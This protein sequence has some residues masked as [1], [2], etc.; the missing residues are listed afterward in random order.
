MSAD[1]R[2]YRETASQ[3]LLDRQLPSGA[4]EPSA[5]LRVPPP[6]VVDPETFTDWVEG[7]RIERAVVLDQ[8]AIFTT[9][10]ALLAITALQSRLTELRSPE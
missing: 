10:T 8:N 1:A 5:R 9:A 3:W 6:D 2:G 7:G 4:W